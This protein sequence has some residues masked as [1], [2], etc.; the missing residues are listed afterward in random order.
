MLVVVPDL[1][2]PTLVRD[3][4]L[5]LEADRPSHASVGLEPKVTAKLAHGRR[6]HATHQRDGTEPGVLRDI[7]VGNRRHLRE[8][9]AAEEGCCVGAAE[10]KAVMRR[11]I[12]HVINEKNLDAADELFS[13]E[14]ELHP[15]TPGI[16]RGGEAMKQAFA[17]L[18]EQFPDVRVTIESI[19]AEEDIVAVRLTYTGTDAATG[20]RAT[21]PEVVFTRFG[22]GKAMESWE[23]LDTGRGPD[24]SPW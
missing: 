9:M 24:S 1:D 11:I 16:G 22:Q 8:L 7:M 3:P 20:E 19:V 12:E 21:W 13:E 4:T 2:E 23:I 6:P 18:H 5:A 14:H 10:N 17:G 15:E